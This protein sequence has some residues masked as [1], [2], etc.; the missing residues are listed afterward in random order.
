MAK[1][2]HRKARAEPRSRPR[3]HTEGCPCPTLGLQPLMNRWPP[4]DAWSQPEASEQ[5][6][7]QADQKGHPELGQVG[8]GGCRPR[9]L[10]PGMG[11]LEARSRT[12]APAPPAPATSVSVSVRRQPRTPP[13]G[14]LVPGNRGS[15]PRP[16]AG[17]PSLLEG[18]G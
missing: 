14:T 17:D 15:G 12:S 4:P 3:G 2:G 13:P 8:A 16:T 10:S 6:R 18:R 9:S 5:A 1:G 7:P 11:R